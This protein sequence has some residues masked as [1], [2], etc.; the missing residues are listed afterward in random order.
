MVVLYLVRHG[1][2]D[3]NKKRLIQGRSKTLLSRRGE[4]SSFLLRDKI[5]EESFDVCFSSPLICAMQTAMILVGD[6]TLILRD[7]RIN[8]RYKGSLEKHSIKDYDKNLF[9]NYNLN[10]DLNGVEKIQDVFLRV[11]DFITYL[12]ENYDGKKILIISHEDVLRVFYHAL[13]NTDL[14]SDLFEP[15]FDNCCYEKFIVK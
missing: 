9:W 2:T 5:I 4:V 1:E 15:R 3:Y 14:N 7:E 12:K 6:R 13:R 10:S 8:A 11:R